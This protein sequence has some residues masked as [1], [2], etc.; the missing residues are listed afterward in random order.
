MTLTERLKAERLARNISRKE[1][2]R[3][4]GI[5]RYT[6]Q[7]WENEKCTQQRALEKWAKAL[8]QRLELVT[9]FDSMP[10]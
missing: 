4:T 9:D 5:S 7:Q 6:L 10:S 8:G 3:R 1:L 2:S